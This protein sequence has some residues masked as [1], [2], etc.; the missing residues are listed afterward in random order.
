MLTDEVDRALDLLHS[1]HDLFLTGR[2]GT[3]KSTLIRR[4]LAETDHPTLVAAPTGIAALTVGGYTI[5]RLFGFH[6]EH[7]VAHVRR[8]A[9]RPGRVPQPRAGAHTLVTGALAMNPGKIP[10][11]PR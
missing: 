6:P 1:G 9:Y 5:H 10:G 11:G 4:F 3:G 8:R 2:A 7:T